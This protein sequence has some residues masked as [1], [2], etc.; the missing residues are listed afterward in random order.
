M[1]LF[2]QFLKIKMSTLPGCGKG[3]F[4]QKFIPKGFII[5]EHTGKITTW[6]DA[7]FTSHNPYLFYV[8]RNHIIDARD[9]HDSYARFVNDATG[10]KRINGFTNNSKYIIIDKRVFITAI[11]D[12]SAGSEIF[13]SYGKEYWEAMKENKMLSTISRA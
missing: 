4:T 6:K 11:K 10:Y 3:L 7:D 2:D 8:T 12:I 13:I 9:E 5:T 1:K